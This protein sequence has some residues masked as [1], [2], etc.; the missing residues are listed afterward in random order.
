MNEISGPFKLPFGKELPQKMVV[1]LHGV[2]ADG[3]DLLSLSDE[4][5]E[6][7][8]PSV[9]L[10]PNAP[11][12]Y[13]M[14]P[15]G[16]Q[17][18][19]L[20]EYTEDKLYEGI[21]VAL[22]ILQNYIEQNLVKYQLNFKDLILIGFSQGAMM[23]V[24]LALRLPEACQAVISYSGAIVKPDILAQEIKSKPPIMLFHGDKDQ[25]LPAE[26]LFNAD[27]ALEKMG[28]PARSY[29]LENVGHSISL[30]AIEMSQNFLKELIK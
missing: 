20:K 22:P 6:A 11:F 18:F 12:S 16:Y 10:A 3:Y 5:V 19:S 13:D 7:L 9:F 15:M 28:I 27:Q 8:P 1:F 25:V 21:K 26:N 23:A 29:L 2:G 4:F 24:Q 14:F 17:W 30:E